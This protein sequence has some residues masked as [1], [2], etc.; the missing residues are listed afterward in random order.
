LGV[1]ASTILS[2]ALAAALGW[3]ASQAAAPEQRDPDV[4]I[5][6]VTDDPCCGSGII[7][8][9]VGI[10]GRAPD[11]QRSYFIPFTTPGQTKP[12]VGERC[13]IGWRWWKS[14]GWN[15]ALAGGGGIWEGREVTNFR[16]RKA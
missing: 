3:S 15:W 10:S 16:C 1:K 12:R 9:A 2:S 11:G 14:S 13:A 6:A 7:A 4:L 8:F 5:T